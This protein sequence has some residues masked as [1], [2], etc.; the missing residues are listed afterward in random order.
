MVIDR[1]YILLI[2]NILT[3]YV[4]LFYFNLRLS[5][6]VVISTVCLKLTPPILLRINFSLIQ[7]IT[8]E[9][10]T[11]MLVYTNI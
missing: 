9:G 3:N 10:L 2:L 7:V 5:S 6:L 4:V 8:K 11:N 1:H